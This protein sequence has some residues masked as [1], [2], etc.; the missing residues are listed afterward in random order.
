MTETRNVHEMSDEERVRFTR[1][2]NQRRLRTVV[3]VCLDES[4]S[5]GE[6]DGEGGN[7]KDATIRAFNDF[8]TAQQAVTADDCMMTVV[9]FSY[10]A[11]VTDPVVAVQQVRPL[12]HLTYTPGG[13][14]A[15]LD[16]IAFCV[17]E[18]EQTEAD[19]YVIA[20]I[21]DGEENSSKETKLAQ[22]REIIAAQ[23]AKGNWT[24]TF[25]SAG[26]DAVR[27]A[28]S[29]GF[30]AANTLPMRNTGAGLAVGTQRFATA[31]AHFRES[32]VLRSHSYYVTSDVTPDEAPTFQTDRDPGDENR[33]GQP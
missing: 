23:E 9:R 32:G 12:T 28:E 29:I 24:F 3:G 4:G 14:T 8:L 17:R 27:Q 22:V 16:A 33:G 21:T 30:A 10:K 5:M 7:K 1:G 19:R 25:L 20:V 13:G 15:L 2:G 18:A 26:L 11:R 31:T 6:P